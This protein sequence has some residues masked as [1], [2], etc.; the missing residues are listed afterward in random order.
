MSFDRMRL[1]ALYGMKKV[2]PDRQHILIKD[3]PIE[4][5]TPNHIHYIFRKVLCI[6]VGMEEDFELQKLIMYFHNK[7]MKRAKKI[8][9]LIKSTGVKV[10]FRHASWE[11]LKRMKL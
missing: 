11:K 5:F 10:E 9:P 1:N 7:T 8:I 4:K 3:I 2:T 6:P